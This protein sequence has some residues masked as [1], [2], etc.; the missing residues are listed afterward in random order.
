[1]SLDRV[2]RLQTGDSISRI[3][4]EDGR[5]NRGMMDVDL[6]ILVDEVDVEG[7]Q[8]GMQAGVL[9]RHQVE[10]TSCT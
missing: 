3:M 7:A 8:I 9:D 4:N 2:V 6:Q 1:V 5:E 10:S